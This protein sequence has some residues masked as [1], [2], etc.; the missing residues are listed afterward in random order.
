MHHRYYI[1]LQLPEALRKTIEAIQQDLLDASVSEP[2]LEPH[3]TLL[4]PPAV[5]RCEPEELGRQA[6]HVAKA[7]LPITLTLTA[8]ETY[9]KHAV[10]ISVQGEEI[11]KLQKD[12]VAL[13]PPEAEAIYYPNPVFSP[14]VTLSHAIRGKAFD[15]NTAKTYAKRLESVLPAT[16]TIDHLTLFKWIAPH[17]YKADL[18]DYDD[19]LL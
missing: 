3:I 8:V 11:Y 15:E 12:L 14:H 19:K 4:P 17:E 9:K 5:E 16:I 6:A 1:G 18:L 10:A 7:H 13:L 2:P